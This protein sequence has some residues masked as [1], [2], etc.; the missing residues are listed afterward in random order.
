VQTSLLRTRLVALALVVAGAGASSS[1]RAD[2]T[3]RAP[4]ASNDAT[5][6]A[7]THFSRGVTYYGEADYPAALVEFDRAYSLA[8][9]WR[10][11]F[12]IGQAHFQLHEYVEAH[13]ALERF[14][15][16]GGDQVKP[17]QRELAQSELASLAER[18]GRVTVDS[19]LVGATVAVDDVV[20]GVTP[21]AS[22]VLMSAG[23]RRVTATFEGRAP[24]EQRISL[25]GGDTREIRLDFAEPP[26]APPPPS[27]IATPVLLDSTPPDSPRRAPNRLP[28]VIAFGA[29][30][31]G[32]AVGGTFGVLALDDR[33]RLDRVCAAG[34]ACPAGDES[35]IHDLSRDALV[36][37]IGFGVAIAA[38]AVGLTLW[39]TAPG[40]GSS[41]AG[42][43]RI[44]WTVGPG[45]VAGTF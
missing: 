9:S 15:R 11:L 26:P 32:A 3:A 22:P 28:A 10:V 44:S 8:P 19:N 40:S 6:E 5:G 34:K 7:G 35:E 31:A 36:S 13:T 43:A 45:G 29:A 24:V 27:A 38:A 37:N 41:R 2:D 39:L 4:N 30:V 1:A 18:I 21:L 17:K 25:A 12:N 23:I 14:L 42:V 20:A 16:E 33:S